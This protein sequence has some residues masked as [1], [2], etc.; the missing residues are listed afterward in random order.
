MADTYKV[1]T[2]PPANQSLEN[3]IDYLRENASDETAKKVRD[4]ILAAIKN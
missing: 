1:I 3:I 4:G 2:T